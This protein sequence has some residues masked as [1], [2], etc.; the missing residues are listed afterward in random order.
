MRI[1][2][3]KEIKNNENRVGLV[4]GGVRQLVMDGHELFV[5]KNA[6]VGIGISD[7]MF[8]N[9]GATILETLEDVFE[10]S[11]MIIKVKEPQ[12]R[13]I[14]LLRPHHI[15]YTYLHLAADTELTK[16]LMESGSTCIAYETIQPAD[17]SL[18]LLTPMSE[19][20]GRMATQ[21][22]ASYLQL[23]HGG[24]GILLG[25][26]PGTRRAR[27][28]VIG[29]GVAGTNSIKMAMGMG[30]DVTAIDLSPKRLA[31]LD[32]LFDNRIT[33]LYSNIENIEQSV[34][35][36]DLV[37]GAVLVPGA[38]APKL[39]TRDM[40]SKMENGSVVVD[41]AVDQGGCIETCKPTTHQNPTF[42][43]DGVV[44][45]C[46]ANMP[47]AVARTSTYA[48]TNVTLQYAR[49]IANSGIMESALKDSA[50][51]KGINIYKGDLV[52]EQVAKDLNLPYTELK[53]G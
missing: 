5:E 13:E 11:E 19:V 14:A 29:C 2:V 3:P 33:T 10:K 51:R 25:G 20:A 28:T 44:H 6:G 45:Y 36:S 7:E 12:P 16:G 42:L 30:A 31:E 37:I 41:I 47:G 40:I 1:G 24:K 9:A 35:N 27:V 32:D 46:V 18:P 49:M 4:P 22:G 43:V 38:K 15:L 52:Y 50:F 17:R 48:L 21:I 23:D 8:I 26:V 53:L 39:V 34:I